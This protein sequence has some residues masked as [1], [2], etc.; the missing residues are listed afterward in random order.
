MLVAHRWATSRAVH[1]GGMKRAT[2]DSSISSDERFSFDLLALRE[3]LDKLA[4]Q[5]PVPAQLVKL[6]SFAGRTGEEAAAVLSRLL[7]IR[8]YLAPR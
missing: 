5:R 6:G 1:V 7:V 2:F 4:D 8:P 3:S